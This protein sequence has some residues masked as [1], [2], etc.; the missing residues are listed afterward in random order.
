MVLITRVALR[1]DICVT[2]AI[3]ISKSV[4]RTIFNTQL[5]YFINKLVIIVILD[6]ENVI[7]VSFCAV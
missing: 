3:L 6:R 7:F 1:K 4:S 2:F 5:L